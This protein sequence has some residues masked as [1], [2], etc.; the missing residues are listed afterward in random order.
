MLINA[1]KPLHN[2]TIWNIRRGRSYLQYI[3][4][5]K[6]I[7]FPYSTLHSF[8][9]TCILNIMYLTFK[10]YISFVSRTYKFIGKVHKKKIFTKTF[11]FQGLACMA[12]MHMIGSSLC[13]WISA[14]VRETVLALT[15]YAQSIYGR[16]DE[17]YGKW[18]NRFKMQ[19][20]NNTCSR[21][22]YLCF[23]CCNYPW[24][25][26]RKMIHAMNR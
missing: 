8:G 11:I 17:E 24:K 10:Y 22:A 19:Y 6:I 12:F 18:Y 21:K 15:I 26:N 5:H 1:S 14:I 2:S 16:Q 4:T 25:S 3:H 7:T 23:C 13:F 20:F 9:T